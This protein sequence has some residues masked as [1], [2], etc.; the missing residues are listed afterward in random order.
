[1]PFHRTLIAVPCELSLGAFSGERLFT[2]RL[3]NG[4]TYT[5]IAPRHKCLSAVTMSIFV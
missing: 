5:S 1:M 3:A 2:I 4:E